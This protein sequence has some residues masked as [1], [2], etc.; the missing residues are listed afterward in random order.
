MASTVAAGAGE[1]QAGASVKDDALGTVE[2]PPESSG[3]AGGDSEVVED[4]KVLSEEESVSTPA[5]PPAWHLDNQEPGLQ[6]SDIIDK[7]NAEV[8]LDYVQLFSAA[9]NQ[10]DSVKWLNVR[11]FPMLK[12]I[13]VSFNAIKSLEGI[14]HAPR[15][16]LLRC[17]SNK[18]KSL[19]G[20]E[21]WKHFSVL[22]EVWLNKN[23]LVNLFDTV[24]SLTAVPG[25]TRLI[26]TRN[27]CCKT[28]PAALYF[29]YVVAML[30][31]LQVLDGEK[32]TKK[33][34]VKAV[35]YISSP[36]GQNLVKQ[37]AARG[38]EG[39]DRGPFSKRP[40]SQPRSARRP[41]RKIEARSTSVSTSNLIPSRGGMASSRGSTAQESMGPP[42]GGTNAA[43]EQLINGSTVRQDRGEPDG[44]DKG[45]ASFT[46]SYEKDEDGDIVLNIPDSPPLEGLGGGAPIPPAPTSP[47]AQVP[48]LPV[49]MAGA[50]QT[51]KP[52]SLESISAEKGNQLSFSSIDSMLPDFSNLGGGKSRTSRRALGSRTKAAK[53][54]P[55]PSKYRSSGKGN[56]WAKNV[57]D[58]PPPP[59]G[60]NE[61]NVAKPSN[62]KGKRPEPVE[63]SKPLPA[64]GKP[65][66][67]RK[68]NPI[69]KNLPSRSNS[70][71]AKVL[72][73]SKID[74]AVKEPTP[75]PHSLDSWEGDASKIVDFSTISKLL[76][77]FS[78]TLKTQISNSKRVRKKT[79][80]LA[81]RKKKEKESIFHS[82]YMRNKGRRK[83][84]NDE[85]RVH[86]GEK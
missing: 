22:N 43:P 21:V 44:N 32:V 42:R 59:I 56:Q 39:K 45:L 57:L 75:L 28:S 40:R 70:M 81:T 77:D 26:L 18:L 66:S 30:P 4:P 3:G 53:R 36:L 72:S 1:D 16:E 63:R 84:T 27:P 73:R 83:M 38:R 25:L 33:D 10:I 11:Y 41:A 6:T 9:F 48:T 80:G 34:R 7:L 76:P 31:N 50:K 20:P 86:R 47:Q 23:L 49:R 12:A 82:E 79:L 65:K 15:L 85:S 55:R 58:V 78:A 13:N 29:H 46:V 69:R 74:K 71:K 24:E 17:T 37:M 52:L 54:P 5:M 8:R 68:P 64:A 61:E 62:T 19:P 67:A 2:M 60:V 14:E 35:N 51:V